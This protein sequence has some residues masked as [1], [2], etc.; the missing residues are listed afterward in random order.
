MDETWTYYDG[1]AFEGLPQGQ[2]TL[3]LPTRVTRKIAPDSDAVIEVERHT[4]DVH[5][6]VTDTLDP[7][8]EPGGTTHRRAYTYDEEQLR[9]VQ[10]DIFLED[11]EGE[12]YILRQEVQYEELFDK[13]I[14]ATAWIEVRDGAPVSPRR[15][16]FFAY[17]T[18]GRITSTVKPGGDTLDDP[19][20]AYVY[21]LSSPSSRIL[22]RKRSQVG[23][24]FDL[25]EVRCMDGRGRGYQ[26]RTRLSDGRYQVT[27]LTRYNVRSNPVEITQ[28][29]IGNSSACDV[30]SPSGVLAT[31]YRYDATYRTLE[32]TVPDGDIYGTP[33]HVRTVYEP[34]TT[35][36]FD[37][38]DND[39]DSPHTD[40][41]SVQRTDGL[42]RLIALE[43]HLNPGQPVT[44]EVTYDS[45]GHLRGYIDP[46][47]NEKVQEYD[48][49]GRV[50]R[51]FDPNTADE[52][53]YQYDDASNEVATTDDR[54]ITTRSA[55]DGMN[56]RVAQWDDAD[57]ESTRVRWFYDVA[58][59][60][61]A[62][63]CTHTA[64]VLAQIDYPLLDGDRGRDFMGFDPRGR[65]MYTA[66][67]LERVVFEMRMTHDNADRVITTTYP[68]GQ[69]LTYAYDGA[70]RKIAVE[71]VVDAITYDDRNLMASTRYANGTSTTYRYDA[72]LRLEEL[73]TADARD[74]V[75]QGFRYTRDR[76]SNILRIDDL[77]DTSRLDRTATY[78]YDAWYRP[79]RALL[80]DTTP[81]T[82][83]FA[84]DTLD[85]ITSKTSDQSDKSPAHVGTYSYGDRPNA[86]TAAG[87]HS[88]AYDPAGHQ[89]QRNTLEM[90][91]DYQG[92][93]TH[94]TR[95]QREVGR[96]LYG[97]AQSRV[98]KIEGDH[99]VHYI[100]GDFELRD[101]IASL[102]VRVGGKRAVRLESEGLAAAVLTDVAPIGEEDGLITAADAWVALTSGEGLIDTVPLSPSP[103]GRLLRSSARRM[104]LDAGP[105]T[106]FFHHDHRGSLTLAT[107]QDGEV[108]GERDFYPFGNMR[109]APLGDVDV[110]GFTGQERDASTDLIRFD[111]RYYD[112]DLGRWTRV[113]PAFAKT[114]PNTIANP[115][116]STTAYAYVGNNVINVVDPTGLKGK[117]LTGSVKGAVGTLRKQHAARKQ[118][119]HQRKLQSVVK[120]NNARI[121]QHALETGKQLVK[122]V[123]ERQAFEYRQKSLDFI[124]RELPKLKDRAVE[125]KADVH[126]SQTGSEQRQQF[127]EELKEVQHNV[128]SF[129][130]Q[131]GIEVLAISEISPHVRTGPSAQV[132]EQQL[133]V[134]TNEFKKFD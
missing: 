47:G 19:T 108:V 111:W 3:G 20:E 123:R 24:P 112:A 8:G 50:V 60:C 54:G 79:T 41:P 106:T 36:T 124:N 62:A 56:R 44:T 52:T 35:L 26:K 12:P 40:T 16:S 69:T 110:Y 72:I 80:G 51:I 71:G 23:G 94:A 39:P 61:D 63:L 2:L 13:P 127:Q 88:L 90:A 121:K 82:L 33:S 11:P 4:Y 49:L 130:R 18:F 43:R 117:S 45:L 5:G 10:T 119:D 98:M 6:N 53:T 128:A 91:W 113:D 9:V 59:D 1:P 109:S 129:E 29:Y 96:F 55:Y 126:L 65:A 95:D 99:V 118:E 32:V 104:L 86:V 30:E 57:P 81:E 134:V 132:L 21:E 31:T 97:A 116:E 15:S 102:Y 78:S 120:Q 85:N 122:D 84:F 73:A 42:G 101:G 105:D 22:V 89:I 58:P 115:G 87:D 38:E 14:K 67:R 64:G 77:G 125:L 66:R 133:Q 131:R 107:A 83:T 7:L 74:T 75:L 103:V 92:R 100:G 46:E 93:L 114:T 25:E 28:P 37:P 17:D 70:S 48:L 76:A 27:G 68:D 34:L